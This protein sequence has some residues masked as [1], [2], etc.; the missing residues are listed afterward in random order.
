MSLKLSLNELRVLVG[1]QL[2]VL[3][4]RISMD[5]LDRRIS[6]SE[7]GNRRLFLIKVLNFKCFQLY[8]EDQKITVCTILTEQLI[9][10]KL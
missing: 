7:A 9:I 1:K 8:T 10:Y 4:I 2:D 6:A 3:Q 5:P